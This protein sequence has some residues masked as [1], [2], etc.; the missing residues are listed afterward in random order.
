VSTQPREYNWGVT[1]IKSSGSGLESREYGRNDPSRWP[2]GILYPQTLALTSPT[3]GSRSVGI[4]RSRLRPWC[5]FFAA[6]AFLQNRYLVTIG[7]CTYWHTDL[8][9][10]GIYEVRRWVGHRFHDIHTKFNKDWFRYPDVDR[11]RHR[12]SQHANLLS[13]LYLVIS[14]I[15]KN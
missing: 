10:S 3:S 14:L 15:L 1:W 6:V 2:R 7:G 4:V 12:H 5:V 11:G 13:L 9:G 8:M